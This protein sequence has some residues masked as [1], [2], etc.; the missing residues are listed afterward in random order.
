MQ[1]KWYGHA[2]FLITSDQGVRIITD[3]YESGAYDGRI[4]YGPISDEADVV[5][6]S[7]DHG[8]HNHAAGVRGSPQVLKVP[9]SWVIQGVPLRGMGTFHDAV[10]GAERG[11]N[12]IFCLEVDGIRVCHLGDL[13]HPLGSEELTAIGQVDLLLPP[14]GGRPATLEPQEITELIEAMRPRLV[15]PMHFKTPKI[16][17][18]FRPLDD[19]LQGKEGVRRLNATEVTLKREGLPARMETWV[20]NHAL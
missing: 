9:G 8:D 10:R 5:T 7:H 14:V 17:F 19:F 16:G 20:L 6:V 11:P 1:V 15:I 18:P 12:T 2:A 3:P 13:G 4:A